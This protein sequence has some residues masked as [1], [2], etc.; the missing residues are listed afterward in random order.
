M[1][2]A[3][4]PAAF[5]FLILLI[6]FFMV[7][8]FSPFRCLKGT[9]H[10]VVRQPLWR[11]KKPDV[12]K[13]YAGSLARRCSCVHAWYELPNFPRFIYIHFLYLLCLFANNSEK[14]PVSNFPD[15]RRHPP[16]QWRQPTPTTHVLNFNLHPGAAAQ[17][18]SNY[19]LNVP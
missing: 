17:Y 7:M 19:R 4:A 8:S 18:R 11:K 6:S 5:A 16:N 14:F 15:V 10:C 9:T 13:E 3:L 2:T 1:A 12:V